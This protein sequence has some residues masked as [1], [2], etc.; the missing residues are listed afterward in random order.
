MLLSAINV[1][2]N[3][4]ILD[5]NFIICFFSNLLNFHNKVFSLKL[6]E[7]LLFI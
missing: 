2:N 6:L 5:Y 3:L 7:N 1:K 4:K